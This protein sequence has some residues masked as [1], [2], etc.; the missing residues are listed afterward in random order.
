[1]YLMK[2]KFRSILLKSVA[3]L[4]G[5][6]LVGFA[7]L[8]NI[9]T[10]S[11][12]TSKAMQEVKVTAATTSDIIEYF[13]IKEDSKGNAI[14]IEISKKENLDHSPI[15]YFSVEGDALD[16]VLHINPVKLEQQGIYEIPIEPNINPVQW[17]DLTSPWKGEKTGTIKIKYLNE[18]IDI[19]MPISFT[20]AYLRQRLLEDINR[21]AV[22]IEK[23][24]DEK[25]LEEATELIT[26]ISESFEWEENNNEIRMFSL[27]SDSI[28]DIER[29]SIDSEIENRDSIE[30]ERFIL[31]SNMYLGLTPNQSQIIST[32]SFK[33][34]PHIERLYSTI[35]N[36]VGILNE[37]L[38]EIGILNAQ[39]EEQEIKIEEQTEK[40]AELEE[41]KQEL[42]EKTE[43]LDKEN[44]E[45]KDNIEALN[46][47]K[48]DLYRE[49]EGIN[50]ENSNLSSENIDLASENSQL[51]AEIDR[52]IKEIEGLRANAG[53]GSTTPEAPS[54]PETPETPSEPETPDDPAEPEETKNPENPEEP[55]NPESP[56]ET[57][58]PATTEEIYHQIPNP[59]NADN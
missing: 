54:N 55:E 35:E 23:V 3:L 24:S 16:Y 39:V 25:A 57:K 43:E 33:I 15:L 17:V 12:F 11:W 41:N 58:E 6:A 50:S 8:I 9:D 49:I 13:N 26:F 47:D 7:F 21:K 51:R 37:K 19:E 52:L 59:E 10:H 18:F 28:Y 5:G 14:A 42:T 40:I 32:I 53:G 34:L 30:V 20:H 31:S 2:Y 56:E 27:E 45:L 38:I 4:T 44:L 22:S 29:F 48:E 1:M 36:L 46:K